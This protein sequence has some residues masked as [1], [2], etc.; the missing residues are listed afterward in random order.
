MNPPDN[1]PQTAGPNLEKLEQDLKELEIKNQTPTVPPPEQLPVQ[2]VPSDTQTPPVPE[3]VV[4]TLDSSNVSSVPPKKSSP[5]MLISIVLVVI[6]LLAAVAYVLGMQF[7]GQETVSPTSTPATACTME[8][9]LCPDGSYVGRTGPN[10]EFSDCP[11]STQAPTV[12]PTMT[13]TPS[14]TPTLSPTPTSMPTST[15]S[16]TPAVN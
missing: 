6:A 12:V 10:C 8:A 9:K 13:A 7:F 4:S 1:N 16:A 3:L 11:I 5:L 15:P 14:G 2:S